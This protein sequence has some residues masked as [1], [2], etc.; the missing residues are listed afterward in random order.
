[1]ETRAQAPPR[2]L[3]GAS[4]LFWGA[5]TDNP[6]LGLMLALLVEGSNWLRFRWDFGDQACTLAWRISLILIIVAGVLIWLD[7]D[8][9]TAL[10]KLMVWLPLLLIPLQ[11][12][13]SFGLRNWIPV[14]SLSFFSKFHRKRNERLGLASSVLRFNFGNVYFITII[15]AASLGRF[16]QHLIFFPCLVI[17]AG[18]LIFSRVRDR[19]FALLMLL[20]AGGAIGLGGQMGMT[21][22]YEWVTNRSSGT[23]GTSGTN[24]TVNK[25]SIGSLGELKQSPEMLWRLTPTPGQA[26]PRLLRVATYNRYKGVF[27]KNDLPDPPPEDEDNFRLLTPLELTDGQP[28][29]LLRE[30]MTRPD[31]EKNL[32][33]FRMRGASASEEP[34]PLPGNTSTIR[35]FEL[36]GVEVNPLG[37]V[38]VFPKKSIIEGS[39]RWNDEVTPDSPPFSREDLLI[40]DDEIEGIEQVADQIGLKDLPSTTAKIKRLRDFF[41]NNF[42]YTRYLSIE[43]PRSSRV[44][45]SAIES[46]LTASQRGHCEYFA[47]A[48]TLLLRAA[49]VPARYCVGFAVMEK[50]PK[51]N[52]WV[53]R[54][55]HG[56]AWTRVW[57]ESR[58]IWID[59]DPT[60]S[61]WIN[62]ESGAVS[63]SQWLSDAYQRFKED[64]FLW[65]NR[66]NNR[67]ASMVVM[68]IL[69]LS[70]FLFVGRRLWKSKLVVNKKAAVVYGNRDPMKTPLHELVKSASKLL[71]PRLPGET[72]ASW[73]G[74][75]ESF[76]IPRSDLEKAVAIHQRLRFDPSPS[77]ADQMHRLAT[78]AGELRKRLSGR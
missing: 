2:L 4:L 73:F 23:G 17:L 55:T 21:E 36:D 37:T 67:I 16:A 63:R 31:V 1:M 59:F 74:K 62:I 53:I 18:W 28:Y 33:T 47:T 32:P 78:I 15:T 72:L 68:W 43:R 30:G 5:M 70:V 76:G 42:E 20:L 52:E 27:W 38:R 64:F 14:N 56:H 65:R 34:L 57:D 12:V 41:T 29:Y 8:R 25:T 44:R 61:N 46:F 75:L 35:D 66:P 11:F 45:P 58:G 51:K 49:D 39:I 60:P 24:P 77:D 3:L 13:Q 9:Y 22:L 69:G 10:P 48:A 19:V 26:P 7:G 50:N 54:G 40:D 71:A 6:F